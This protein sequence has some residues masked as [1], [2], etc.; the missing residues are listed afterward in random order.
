MYRVVYASL[1][2]FEELLHCCAAAGDSHALWKP[3]EAKD[4]RSS[5]ELIQA[6]RQERGVV[7]VWYGVVLPYGRLT[8]CS[9]R[10]Y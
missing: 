3:A 7:L 4:S 9:W 2:A 5:T 1:G 6:R 8:S 10:Q